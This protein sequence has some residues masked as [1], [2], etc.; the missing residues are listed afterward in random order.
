M[1]S[2]QR[3]RGLLEVRGWG[4]LRLAFLQDHCGNV[5]R[6]LER[7]K[8]GQESSGEAAEMALVGLSRGSKRRTGRV[9]AHWEAGEGI[10]REVTS[11][12][13]RFLIWTTGWKVVPFT[14]TGRKG[15]EVTSESPRR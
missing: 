6:S 15:E 2:T 10:G 5:Q 9:R 1:H 8:R 3:T 11:M 7:R 14:K 13:A 4:R 12:T